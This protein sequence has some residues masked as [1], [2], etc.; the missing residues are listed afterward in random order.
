[1]RNSPHP[2][3]AGDHPGGGWKAAR[4]T[5]VQILETRKPCRS[6][7]LF[8]ESRRVSVCQKA[9][10][11]VTVT[12]SRADAAHRGGYFYRQ[13]VCFSEKG[14]VNK[15][16]GRLP[17]P[18]PRCERSWAPLATV[19]VLMGTRP[20]RD[21]QRGPGPR[22][23]GS[24]PPHR[25]WPAAPGWATVSSSVRPTGSSPGVSRGGNQRPRFSGAPGQAAAAGNARSDRLVC[26]DPAAAPATL[27]SL[28][29]GLTPH[30][31]VGPRRGLAGSDR[32]PWKRRD[33]LPWKGVGCLP[34]GRRGL[35]HPR[36]EQ[37]GEVWSGWG[38]LLR[39]GREA[40][41]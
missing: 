10:G 15:M 29:P 31:R 18:A 8:P 32:G 13:A 34:C 25:S 35:P 37:E 19:P 9:Q 24:W 33:Q 6:G 23:A 4:A 3:R 40:C 27:P 36:A 39:G 5:T 22:A 2:G 26:G 38:S 16:V 7:I 30:D 14:Q 17:A 28:P 20:C 11:T 21:G 12:G 1:M 41:G